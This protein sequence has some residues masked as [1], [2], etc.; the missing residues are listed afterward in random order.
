MNWGRIPVFGWLV[1]KISNG[2][3][4]NELNQNTAT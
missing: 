3:K 1:V 2:K 4:E